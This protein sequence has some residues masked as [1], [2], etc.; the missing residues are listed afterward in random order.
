MKKIT[1]CFSFV[2]LCLSLNLMAQTI[3]PDLDK[4]ANWNLINRLC[5]AINENGRS[6]VFLTESPGD[7]VMVLK[8]IE[9]SSGI[10]EADIKGKDAMGQSFVGIAFHVQKDSSYDAVYFRPFNFFNADT[11]RRHRAVQYISI[12]NYPWEKLRETWPRKYESNVT[13]VPNANDWFHVKLMVKGN[14]IKAFVNNETKPCLEVEKLSSTT[15]GAIALWVGNN[16]SGA[17]ANL[18]IT[19]Q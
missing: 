14:T 9:F 2:L 7:G 6:G 15:K 18:K 16:S 12:P 4:K 17:F 19:P 3:S 5:V 1:V 13:S 8:D 11:A 10:I